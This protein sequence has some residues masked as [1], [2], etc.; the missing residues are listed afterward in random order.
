MVLEEKVLAED[1][2]VAKEVS[3]EHCCAVK[4]AP[5]VVDLVVM[6]QMSQYVVD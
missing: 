2:L 4:E 6:L 5:Q 1:L 3:V